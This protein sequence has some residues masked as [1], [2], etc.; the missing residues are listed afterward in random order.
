M[1]DFQ[2]PLRS[3]ALGLAMVLNRGVVFAPE[4]VD[5]ELS[6]FWKW[7]VNRPASTRDSKRT[8]ISQGLWSN[9]DTNRYL[10][11]TLGF[12]THPDVTQNW[13]IELAQFQVPNGKIGVIRAYEQFLSL[14]GV[15]LSE[16]GNP[17][18]G[19]GQWTMRL[20]RYNGQL[21]QPINQLSP[22]NSLP[23]LPYQDYETEVGLWFPC[24]SCSANNIQL[25]VPGGFVLRVFWESGIGLLSPPTVAVKMRGSLQSPYSDRTY[26]MVTGSWQ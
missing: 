14:N 7:V 13:R 22:P 17:N 10:Q 21:P 25:L 11:S 24:G 20:D 15:V 3:E 18:V 19:F 8:A 26:T 1:I 6:G 16:Q 4:F 9:P 5:P 12:Y 2:N 23:G